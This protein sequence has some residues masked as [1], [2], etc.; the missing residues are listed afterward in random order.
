[1]E[2]IKNSFE[3][4]EKLYGSPVNIGRPLRCLVRGSFSG[5]SPIH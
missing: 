1:M 4:A 3:G 2:K 5:E